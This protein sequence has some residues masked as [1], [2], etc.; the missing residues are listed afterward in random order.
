MTWCIRS[1]FN[2]DQPQTEYVTRAD[3]EA[4]QGLTW[5]RADEMVPLDAEWRRQTTFWRGETYHDSSAPKLGD[6]VAAGVTVSYPGRVLTA[7]HVE[8]NVAKLEG[9]VVLAQSDRI[10]VKDFRSRERVTVLRDAGMRIE[11]RRRMAG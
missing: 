3:K 2:K 4:A 5:I 11:H 6:E 9:M 7:E 10:V 1:G 8:A